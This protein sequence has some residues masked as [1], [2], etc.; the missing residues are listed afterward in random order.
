MTPLEAGLSGL[1]AS[2]PVV[3]K[4][5][6]KVAPAPVMPKP[7]PVDSAFVA[8]QEADRKAWSVIAKY[9]EKTTGQASDRKYWVA[10]RAWYAGRCSPP[11]RVLAYAYQKDHF[12]AA[13]A[14][15]KLLQL[16]VPGSGKNQYMTET[17]EGY[18]GWVSEVLKAINMLYESLNLSPNVLWLLGLDPM[19]ALMNQQIMRD[20]TTYGRI[21]PEMPKGSEPTYWL[22]LPRLEDKLESLRSQI[23]AAAKPSKDAAWISWSTLAITKFYG[24]P[25]DVGDYFTLGIFA[26]ST[27]DQAGLDAEARSTVNPLTLYSAGKSSVE[28]SLIASYKKT[29][30][31]S[32]ARLFGTYRQG[33]V[34]P[35]FDQYVVGVKQTVDVLFKWIY[36]LLALDYDKTVRAGITAWVQTYVFPNLLNANTKMYLT[37]HDFGKLKSQQH[38]ANV[39]MALDSIIGVGQAF[40][41][42]VS[43][44]VTNVINGVKHVAADVSA[45]SPDFSSLTVND[46]MPIPELSR[47]SFVECNAS[48]SG[49]QDTAATTTRVLDATDTLLKAAKIPIDWAEIIGVTAGSTSTNPTPGSMPAPI[50]QPPPPLVLPDTGS[51][52]S[53]NA[54]LIGGAAV[55]GGILLWRYLK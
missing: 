39:M 23:K 4:S 55:I 46:S 20:G 11:E 13:K 14:R 17:P 9:T 26:G 42:A 51:T 5:S 32:D 36:D 49:D 35:K 8:A 54:L 40:F 25:K 33:D 38:K 16:E 12:A 37:R 19:R 1:G 30:L 52:V 41:G 44:N 3:S 15:L 47:R 21:L 50:V 34:G 18:A 43:G 28:D 22:G 29:P 31:T 53:A 10:S 2:S 24:G 48:V 45:G 7:T 27:G 6:S